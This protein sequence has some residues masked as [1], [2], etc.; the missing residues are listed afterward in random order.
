VEVGSL[1]HREKQR[2]EDERIRAVDD[3]GAVELVELVPQH[4]V[5]RSRAERGRGSNRFARRLQRQH[6]NLERGH[7]CSLAQHARTTSEATMSDQTAAPQQYAAPEIASRERVEALL[8]TTRSDT[9]PVCC[10]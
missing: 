2:A 4:V 1:V 9:K 6:A 8:D 3:R 10:A 5:T 7:R